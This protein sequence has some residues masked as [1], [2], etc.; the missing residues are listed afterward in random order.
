MKRRKRD[1]ELIDV[2]LSD[3]ETL[4]KRIDH[5]GS[6]ESSFVCDRSE[7]G[8]LAYDA[9]MS[10]V[11]RIA[12][13]A[14]HL[15]DEVQSAFPEYPWNDIRGFRNFIAHGYREVDRSLA[16]KVIVD[17]IPELEKALRIFKE[18]QS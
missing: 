2:I 4:T 9:I 14:L 10:P 12:E 11:Y 18:R 15:S 1:A 5:F 3:C 17:D 8:E 16:W 6:T 7:E 13:D